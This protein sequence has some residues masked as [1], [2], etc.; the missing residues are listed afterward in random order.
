MNLIYHPAAEVE[1]WEAVEYYEHCQVGLGHKFSRSFQEVLS[2]LDQHPLAWPQLTGEIRR[3]LVPH[4]P[5][6]VIYQW[7]DQG[8]EILAIM[9][10]HRNP[11]Y[12]KSRLRAR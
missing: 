11:D 4:F 6:A 7:H 9:H 5:Y 10:L 3:C 8:I 12:W 2:L 1:L